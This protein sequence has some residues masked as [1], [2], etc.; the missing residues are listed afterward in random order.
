LRR[1]LSSMGRS[2]LRR[3]VLCRSCA[4]SR[5]RESGSTQLEEGGTC[6]AGL[7]SSSEVVECESYVRDPMLPA[8]ILS[9]RLENLRPGKLQRQFL[10]RRSQ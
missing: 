9:L 1:K 6:H 10:L 2:R 5:F 8:N 4:N 3:C 7:V